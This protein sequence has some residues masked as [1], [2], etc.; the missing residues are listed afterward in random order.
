[1]HSVCW[2]CEH[3][4]LRLKV[5]VPFD[6]TIKEYM[7]STGDFQS[8]IIAVV[9]E[10]REQYTVWYRQGDMLRLVTF[11]ILHTCSLEKESPP[12]GAGCPYYVQKTEPVQISNIT[13]SKLPQHAKIE[14]NLHSTLD[15]SSPVPIERK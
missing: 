14:T 9:K 13:Y 4:M 2:D 11:K 3:N 15:V 1:M 5:L 7:H 12:K 6:R 10:K 8:E